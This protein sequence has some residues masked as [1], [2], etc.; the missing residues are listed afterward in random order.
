M[1]S[2]YAEA[3][4]YELLSLGLQS[5]I[6]IKAGQERRDS[7]LTTRDIEK[8]HNARRILEERF[9]EP[10]KIAELARAVGLNEAKLMRSFKQVF[11]PTIFDF[12]QQL[13]MELAKKLIETTDMSV[14]EIALDVGYE[15]SSNFTTAF[16][17]H[18]GITPKAARDA[19]N[20]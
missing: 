9:L 2:L 16:K 17:R 10:P 3:K 6:D 7:G 20:L 1:R 5:L 15:Y 14:T 19:A 11:G 13:R 8:I 12:S 4:A 18:F